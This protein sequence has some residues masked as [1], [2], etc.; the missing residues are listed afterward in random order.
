M[1]TFT[2]TIACTHAC[3][4]MHT[5]ALRAYEYTRI[6]SSTQM[7]TQAHILARECLQS[8]QAHIYAHIL[9]T[10]KYWNTLLH[11]LTY[12]L[13][14]TSGRNSQI[15]THCT[16]IS[17]S[18]HSCYIPDYTRLRLCTRNLHLSIYALL[19]PLML[20]ASYTYIRIYVTT[21]VCTL[22]K[23]TLAYIMIHAYLY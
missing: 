18:T 15:Y 10:Y 16:S 8:A 20:Y 4:C 5:S 13:T 9:Q 12:A 14:P 23:N 3:I 2:C 11:M 1:H 6:H 19:R 22:H 21:C 17:K 7:Q